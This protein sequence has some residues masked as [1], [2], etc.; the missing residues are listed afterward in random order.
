[1]TLT[2]TS[3]GDVAADAAAPGPVIRPLSDPVDAGGA[4]RVVRGNLAPDGALIKRSAASAS[5]LAHRGPAVV[6]RSA[7]DAEAFATSARGVDPGS[8]IVL[9]GAG[10]VGGPGM[11]EWA[12]VSLPPD[13]LAQGVSDMVRVSDARMSGT[14]FGTVFLHVA[15]EAAVGGTIGLVNDGDVISVDAD[16]GR[17]ELEV[18]EAELNA[19]RSRPATP[20]PIRRGYLSLY[21]AHVQQAPDGCDFDFLAGTPGQPPRLEEPVVG[22]S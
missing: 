22:R 9:A 5:L 3:I 13:V 17:I 1:M 7:A 19:R 8:V 20:R 18:G 12:M 10:P 11:P 2:G 14:S 4:F 16:A 15:P 6:L 21:A